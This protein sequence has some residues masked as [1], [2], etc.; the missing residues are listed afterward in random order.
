MNTNDVVYV[1]GHRNPDSDSIC[2]AIAYAEYLKK[3]GV[4]AVACRLGDITRETA[5]I[6][7]YFDVEEPQILKNV[8]TQISDLD[9]DPAVPVTSDSTIQKAWTRMK[10]NNIKTLPV[11]D[12]D[13]HLFGLITLSDI[14]NKYLDIL[15]TNVI[16]SRQS[17]LRN[18]LE[19]L[20]ATLV[21]GCAECFPESGKLVIAAMESNEMDPY[22]EKSDIVIVG[23]RQDAQLKALECKVSSI[24]VTGNA[25]IS[26]EVIDMAKSTNTIV[27]SS[28][29]DTF[30]TS[31]LITQSIMVACIMTTENLIRFNIDDFVS[32]IKTKMLQ[33]RYRSYPVVDDNN[34]IKGFIS[35]YHL[36]S[37][38]KKKVIL[39]DH[40]EKSQTVEGIEEAEILEIIDH[41]RYGDIQTAYPIHCKLEPVGS[42]ATIIAN[43]FFENA[44]RPSRSIAGLLCAAIIS[45]TMNFKSPTTVYKDRMTAEKLAE[46]NGINIE[47]FATKMIQEGSSI[48]GKTAKEIIHEDYKEF[49]LGT[50]KFAISQIKTMDIHC[51]DSIEK[52]I[53]DY[54]NELAEEKKY[55]LVML[56]I[57]DIIQ[58]GSLALITGERYDLIEKAFN[59]EVK[60]N[61]VFLPGLVSRKK[62]IIPEI[63]SIL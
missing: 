5:F 53:F 36:I 44:I 23:N 47:E 59:V 25:K 3:N 32:D 6:L 17:T 22:I 43:I 56:V 55:D 1:T 42:T 8:K 28:P 61:R 45:D 21:S 26:K 41:H 34:V 19:T 13:N 29:H 50:H 7:D 52:E 39:V 40:N 62:Q 16:G 38:R 37:S 9:I 10:L 20:N 2:S 48:V 51:V 14:A 18:V 4:N 63:S 54:M 57:T 60:N 33:T 58:E 27:M 46:I 12:E 11:V 35:R 15:E 31:R 30:T 24:I 49:Q